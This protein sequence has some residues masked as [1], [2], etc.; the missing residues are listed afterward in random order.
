MKNYPV[1]RYVSMVAAVALVFVVILLAYTISTPAPAQLTKE[2]ALTLMNLQARALMAT[3]DRN[4][5][6]QMLYAKYGLAPELY[7]I[8]IGR[9][10][11]VLRTVGP[12]EPSREEE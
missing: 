12:V 2:E 3:A 11:F 5:Y 7:D 1:F 9:G 4:E 8:D 6:A 10:R